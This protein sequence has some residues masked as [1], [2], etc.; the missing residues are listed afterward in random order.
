[1]YDIFEHVLSRAFL[2][3]FQL[4]KQTILFLDLVFLSVFPNWWQA[5]I[6]SDCILTP[7]SDKIEETVFSNWLS[8]M[9]SGIPDKTK[10]FLLPY[11]P[12]EFRFCS[13]VTTFFSKVLHFA[14]SFSFS[15]CNCLIII[16]LRLKIYSFKLLIQLMI[17]SSSFTSGSW[18]EALSLLEILSCR[19]LVLYS[20]GIPK[21]K[22]CKTN[23]IE[24]KSPVFSVTDSINQLLP[25]IL[26]SLGHLHL[27]VRSV[28]ITGFKIS[29]AILPHF[30][31]IS[32]K[33]NLFFIFLFHIKV[34]V[35]LPYYNQR[36]KVAS[37]EK[38]HKW[39]TSFKIKYVLKVL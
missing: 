2:Q 36:K 9:L 18:L 29:L 39:K 1:M 35:L 11:C 4:T 17:L 24:N 30:V 37:N 27:K 25:F 33:K 6:S 10:L 19:R 31:W 22:N 20:C 21:K 14:L 8:G 5:S 28:S 38:I 15:S 7:M 23:W 16:S 26:T 13:R 34:W 3:C 12:N 32:S